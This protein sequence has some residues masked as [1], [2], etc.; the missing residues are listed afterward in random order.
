MSIFH[1]YFGHLKLEIV[2]ALKEWKIETSKS[3]EFLSKDTYTKYMNIVQTK[4]LN[5]FWKPEISIWIRDY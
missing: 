1:K 3:A 2:L 5:I 4:K